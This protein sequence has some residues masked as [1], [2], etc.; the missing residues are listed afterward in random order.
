MAY[1]TSM[2]VQMQAQKT[3][4]KTQQSG[5]GTTQD[6]VTKNKI[7]QEKKGAPS[8]KVWIGSSGTEQSRIGK[9]KVHADALLARAPG[10]TMALS[11]GPEGERA[12]TAC[13]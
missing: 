10:S 3:R 6:E 2:Q 13:A 1:C 12:G 9:E 7:E 11:S 5:A 4:A 8:S